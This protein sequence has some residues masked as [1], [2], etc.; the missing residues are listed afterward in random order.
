VPSLTSWKTSL[1]NTFRLLPNPNQYLAPYLTSEGLTRA[2]VLGKLPYAAKRARSAGTGKPDARRYR[3]GK[4]I[5][6]ACGLL[7]EDA[8]KL[9]RITDFGVATRRW[10]SIINKENATILGRHAAYALAA[11]QLRNPT[12]YGGGY[13]NS[14]TVFPFAFIWRAM[15]ALDGKINSDELSRAIFKVK[16]E[17]D[18]ATAID[19]ISEA[20]E[21]ADNEIMGPPIE[22]T[23]D[24]IIPWI[25]LASF[26]W[27][28]INDKR[29]N[30]DGYYT[31]PENTKEILKDASAIHHPHRTFTSVEEYVN[32]ISHSASLPVDLR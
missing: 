2:A 24:R 5:F 19:R 1:H 6:E 29:A 30:G 32:Y 18:L 25:A 20:R 8:D 21:H 10:L 15:L 9:V 17:A 4:Q 31:I 27:A 7:F 26:G 28:L 12:R 13:D 23:N 3:D 14:V 11:C 16:D 22:T